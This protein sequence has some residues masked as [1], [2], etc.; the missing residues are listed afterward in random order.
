MLCSSLSSQATKVHPDI[1]EAAQG[2]LD[3]IQDLMD[4]LEETA[5]EYGMVT[6]MLDSISKAIIIVSIVWLQKRPQ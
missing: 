3:G 6:P 2:M 5:S 4:T 1:E